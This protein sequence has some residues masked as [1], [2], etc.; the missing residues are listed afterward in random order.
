MRIVWLVSLLQLAACGFNPHP[1]SGALACEKG[2]PSGYYCSSEG[3]CWREET[4]PGSGGAGGNSSS[5][6]DCDPLRPSLTCGE[7][8]NCAFVCDPQNQPKRVC[9]SGGSRS[10]GTVCNELADCAPGSACFQYS[11]SG[12][13]IKT[14]RRFCSNDQGCGTGATCSLSFSCSASSE[15]AR[16]CSQPC[17]PTGSADDGCAQGLYCFVYAG[18]VTDCACRP[19]SRVGANGQKCTS[20]DSCAPGSTCV[21][22]GGQKTCRPI[23]SLAAASCPSGTVCTQL[24]GYRVYGACL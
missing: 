15:E 20:D 2:C 21:D 12:T 6:T 5:G 23:C 11:C 10:P 24:T 16:I 3:T 18:E 22:R 7:G 9:L 14:C 17:D 1:Q 4:S 13:S 19:S 8:Q